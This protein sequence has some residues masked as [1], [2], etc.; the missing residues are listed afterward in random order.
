[1]WELPIECR[2]Y[3]WHII[4]WPQF[5]IAN[6]FTSWGKLVEWYN[7]KK[8]WTKFDK[9]AFQGSLLKKVTQFSGCVEV[10]VV[11]PRIEGSYLSSKPHPPCCVSSWFW[12]RQIGLL[13]IHSI[14]FVGGKGGPSLILLDIHNSKNCSLDASGD[15]QQVPL[16][17]ISLFDLASLVDTT[18]SFSRLNG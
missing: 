11:W 17:C 9:K 8:I 6:W 2:I 3:H 7:E 10:F 4:T 14:L 1:M 18:R 13:N 15:W 12:S 16:S 5:R